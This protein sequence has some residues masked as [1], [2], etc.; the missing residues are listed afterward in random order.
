MYQP[1]VAKPTAAEIMKMVTGLLPNPNN[2][3]LSDAMAAMKTEAAAKPPTGAEI[4]KM[5]TGLL[6]NPNNLQMSDALAALKT[7][8]A[9]TPTGLLASTT[10]APTSA[11]IGKML[12][13]LLPNPNNLTSADMAAAATREGILNPTVSATV[14][15]ATVP[16]ATVPAAT[17]PA[18]TVPAATVPAATNLLTGSG[19]IVDDTVGPVN[20]RGVNTGVTT[21][22]AKTEAE[23]NQERMDLISQVNHVNVGNEQTK[24]ATQ[25][26]AAA[27]TGIP[28]RIIDKMNATGAP[29]LENGVYYQPIYGDER[30]SGETYERGS[31]TSYVSYSEAENKAGGAYTT[32]D[33]TGK[34]IGTG[35]QQEV[36]TGLKSMIAPLLAGV[37]MAVGLPPS[38]FESIF[39]TAGTIA[40]ESVAASTVVPGTGMT[41]AE[42]TQLDLSIGG[43]GAGIDLAASMTGV[44]AATLASEVISTVAASPAVAAVVPEAAATISQVVGSDLAALSGTAGATT[45]TAAETAAL[46][47]GAATTAGGGGL[48][49]AP[50]TTAALTSSQVAA[51]APSAFAGEALADAGLL[52]GGTG[53]TAAVAPAAAAGTT[54]AVA[55]AAAAGTTAAALAP[56]AVAPA[57]AAPSAFAGETLANAGLLSGGTGMTAAELGVEAAYGGITPAALAPAA[58][59]PAAAL[60]PAAVAPAAA[61]AGTTA[62]TLAPAAAG[63]AAATG[64]LSGAASTVGST[65]ADAL[66]APGSIGGLLQGAGGYLQTEESKAAAKLAAQNMTAATKAATEGAQFKP[67]GT[68][69]R[70][71][72]SQFGYDPTT[73]QMTSAGYTLSPEAKAQQDRFVAL[74]NAGLTQAEQA[75]AQFAPL[76]TGAQS[77]FRLGN[78]YLAQ[79]PQNVARNYLEQQMALLAP[80][81]E[82][83]LANLQNKLQQQGRVGLSVAQG[84]GYGA[85]T[86]ELQAMYNARAMQE[87]QLAANAEQAGQ[88]NVLFGAGLLGQGSTAMG[89]Y[90][91]GQ[92]QAY[93][94]YTTASNQVQG[95]EALGQAPM[96]TSF[97]IGRDVSTAGARAGQLGIGGTQAAGN[98][99]TNSAATVNPLA[100]IL[101][102][103]GGSNAFT[104]TLSGLFGGVNPYTSTVPAMGVNPYPANFDYSNW[105]F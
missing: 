80:G 70:F 6:P 90:Y 100:N 79:N 91:G 86:P 62:A 4:M 41:L 82:L 49:T 20:T 14:P 92:Q 10:P 11:E 73:G 74:Q 61:A 53:M 45:L 34:E 25:D 85:T 29:V 99:A 94:P 57:A 35:V 12:V 32:H 5:V 88:R 96:T 68:T 104:S 55:P 19:S 64:L 22:P 76:R 101:G 77:M 63:T 52:S 50:A 75:Q 40:A 9:V 97:G 13:G 27:T 48:L 2:L 58:V 60:A 28:Q 17:V 72:T 56:A 67:I 1:S 42:L 39:G 36:D 95:L 31:P 65:L 89:N 87:A 105:S 59:A 21:A 103:L 18:A 8:A 30:G 16:A 47:G 43:T 3:Q 37:S 66:I 93:A 54:A 98:F 38:G 69:T 26:I 51:A 46:T 44:P 83:E 7:E 33:L 81:R 78:Q 15:A 23:L 71:G 102:G 84:G 24:V